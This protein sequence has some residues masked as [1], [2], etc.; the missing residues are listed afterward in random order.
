M[1]MVEEVL[2]ESCTDNSGSIEISSIGG[3][4]PIRYSIDNGVTFQSSSL[5]TGLGFGFYDILVIDENGCSTTCSAEVAP[6]CFDLALNK[7]TTDEGP[8]KYGDI[9]TFD[10]TVYNQGNITATNIE[11]IEYMPCGYEFIP[12]LNPQWIQGS[13]N[14]ATTLI[15]DILAE[16]ESTSI[17]ISFV[18]QPCSEPGAWK[19]TGEIQ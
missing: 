18:I 11:V 14:T 15:T 8:F 10:F 3:T 13:G 2:P 9:I 16:G 4:A 6:T 19:N 17:P 7:T 1:C 12:S 5:F